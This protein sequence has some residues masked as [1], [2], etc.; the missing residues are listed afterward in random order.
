MCSGVEFAPM[1]DRRAS[2]SQRKDLADLAIVCWEG[3]DGS[4]VHGGLLP[5]SL[6]D[7]LAD[8]FAH[9]WPDVTYDVKPAAQLWRAPRRGK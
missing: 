4:E 1:T 7:A 3:P 5:R 8:A 9:F 6:A 2:T